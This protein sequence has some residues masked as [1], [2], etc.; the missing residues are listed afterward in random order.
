MPRA[1]GK[2]SSARGASPKAD[3]AMA[4]LSEGID[5]PGVGEEEIS[6][7]AMEAPAPG[8]GEDIVVAAQGLLDKWPD[9]EHPYYKDLEALVME[10]SS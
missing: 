8:G 7:E 9:K 4:I 1:T 3:A 10:Y 6:A 2:R 5:M